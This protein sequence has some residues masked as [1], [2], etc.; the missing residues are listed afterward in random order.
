MAELEASTCT[1]ID[2]VLQNES[3][4]DE[5]VQREYDHAEVY[6][7]LFIEAKVK[8]SEY[9]KAREPVK[10]PPTTVVS[11]VV[12]QVENKKTHRLPKIEL[13]KFNGKYVSGCSFGAH[14][15]RYTKMKPLRLKISSST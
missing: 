9:F 15:R 12:N 10:S 3:S 1:V 8:V 2:S 4:K 5:D 11:N 7:K 14:L 6:E 13:Y